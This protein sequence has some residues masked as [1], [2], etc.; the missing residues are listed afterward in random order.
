MCSPVHDHGKE[1]RLAWVNVM[2]GTLLFKKFVENDFQQ[3]E[4]LD[5]APLVVN[6]GETIKL[7]DGTATSLRAVL[8]MLFTEID[9][10]RRARPPPDDEPKQGAGCGLAPLVRSSICRV[11]VQR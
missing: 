5:E 1:G 2:S 9:L 8:E 7:I 11:P 10:R 3:V 4:P 6:T